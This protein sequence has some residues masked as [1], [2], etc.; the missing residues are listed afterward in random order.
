MVKKSTD[1]VIIGLSRFGESLVGSLLKQK[2]NIIVLDKNQEKVNRIADKVAFAACLDSTNQ[3]A[4]ERVGVKSSDCVIVAM[5]SDF[6]SGIMTVVALQKLGV[7][8]IYVKASASSQA[9]VYRQLGIENLI[10][11]EIETAKRLAMKLTHSSL[12]DF[13][14]LDKDLAIVQ[15]E[16]L[17]KTI[18]G[19]TIVEL[20]VRE[21]LNVNI[22]AIKRN[23]MMI[24]PKADEIMQVNDLLYIIA[25]T[26]TLSKVE[27]FFGKK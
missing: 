23:D 8:N 14:N 5:G 24:M 25:N 11:P 19:K 10:M 20:N 6:E 3:D 17:N 16:V 7:K 2:K 13:V 18:I 1:F 4:L 21:K 26:S 12:K 15:V 27:K 9:K 22:I